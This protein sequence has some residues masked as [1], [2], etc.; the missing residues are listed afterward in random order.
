LQER[1]SRNENLY[2]SVDAGPTN[3]V[4][5]VKANDGTISGASQSA[6]CSSDPVQRVV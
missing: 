2:S 5:K 1:D 3:P 6:S 4:L